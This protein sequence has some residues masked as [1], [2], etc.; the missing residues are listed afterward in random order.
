MLFVED[1][2]AINLNLLP[3]FKNSNLKIKTKIYL[4]QKLKLSYSLI[5]ILNLHNKFLG[6]LEK[7]F[8]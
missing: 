4:I 7:F 2:D 3:L 5:S 6:T 8:K 1:T